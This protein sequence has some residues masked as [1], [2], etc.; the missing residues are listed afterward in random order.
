MVEDIPPPPLLETSLLVVNLLSLKSPSTSLH[1][2]R[3]LSI[4]SPPQHPTIW[5]RNASACEDGLRW[6]CWGCWPEYCC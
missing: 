2:N 1:K 4:P 3:L 5:N 6:V